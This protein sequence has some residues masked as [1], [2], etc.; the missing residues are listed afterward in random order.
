MGLAISLIVGATGMAGDLV[1]TKIVELSKKNRGLMAESETAKGRV[2][3]LTRRIQELE[4]EV[5]VRAALPR[6]DSEGHTWRSQGTVFAVSSPVSATS[7]ERAMTDSQ[8]S[9]AVEAKGSGNRAC[10][11]LRV[12]VPHPP[13]GHGGNPAAGFAE[14]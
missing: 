11:K 1:A 6:G 2:K 13:G 14:R 12:S 7:R 3:Q 9:L 4:H 5:R 10:P 8:G